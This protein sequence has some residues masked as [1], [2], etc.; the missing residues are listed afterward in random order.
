MRDRAV[1]VLGERDPGEARR[2]FDR[3]ELEEL[4]EWALR[5]AGSAR[6]AGTIAWPEGVAAGSEYALGVRERAL[7]QLAEVGVESSW[8]AST[9]DRLNRSDLRQRVLR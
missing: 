8:L 4:R 5:L 9:Y 7:R 3:L 1:R 6:D 2:L